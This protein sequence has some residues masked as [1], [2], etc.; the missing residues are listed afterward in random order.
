MLRVVLEFHAACTD[1]AVLAQLALSLTK[2]RFL[3]RNPK[4]VSMYLFVKAE[5]GT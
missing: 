3:C 2:I 1:F 5:G 4:H